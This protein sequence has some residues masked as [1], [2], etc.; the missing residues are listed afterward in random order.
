[1][2]DSTRLSRLARVVAGLALPAVAVLGAAP[3]P[4]AADGPDPADVVL[5]V[6]DLRGL[7]LSEACRLLSDRTGLNVVPS[8]AAASQPVTLFLR[9]VPAMV[10]VESL[11]RANQ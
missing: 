10:A 9:D 6:V 8:A 5:D 7:P 3:R 4:A 2:S 1:M 11:C